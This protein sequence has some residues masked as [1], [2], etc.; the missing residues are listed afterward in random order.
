MLVVGLMGRLQTSLESI[1][2]IGTLGTGLIK[3]Q[4]LAN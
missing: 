4:L 2:D 3:E 1:T